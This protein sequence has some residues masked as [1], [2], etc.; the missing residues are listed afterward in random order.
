MTDTI[1]RGAHAGS[2]TKAPTKRTREVEL[3]EEFGPLCD[4]LADVKLTLAEAEARVKDITGQLKEAAGMNADRGETLVIRIA[5]RIRAKIGL[6]AK[7][8]ANLALLLES[9]PEAYGAVVGETEYQ[10]VRPA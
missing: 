6:Q 3:P 10:V 7:P 9:F 2:A 8:V 4:E 5:G 1:T